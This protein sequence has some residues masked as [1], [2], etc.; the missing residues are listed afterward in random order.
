[1]NQA[2]PGKARAPALR[3]ENLEVG[4]ANG[5]G[6]VTALEV[7]Q[8]GVP[9]GGLLAVTGPS[10]SGKST[11][12]YAIGGLLRPRRG[13]VLWDEHDILSYGESARDRWRRHTVGFAFQ[14][15]HLLPE[16]TPLQNVLL[17]ASFEHF[18]ATPAVRSRAVSLLEHFSVPQARRSTASLSRGEQQRVAIARAL[19]FDPP[20][21]LADEPTA[22]LDAKAGGIVI[23]ILLQLSQAD[24][25]TVI[26]IS[27]DQELLKRSPDVVALDHGRLTARQPQMAAQAAAS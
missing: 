23:D 11:L 24:H 8:L 27:H 10:G 17:P 26:A 1:M 14:D 16:L 20:V 15:F 25:R 18:A 21:I 13:K 2:K 6:A 19:L 22:S 3:I 12:L 5:A 7:E 9:P 4:Y